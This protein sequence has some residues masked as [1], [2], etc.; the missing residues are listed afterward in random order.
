MTTE[1][2]HQQCRRARQLAEEVVGPVQWVTDTMGHCT[3]PGKT[4]HEPGGS[5]FPCSL[6]LEGLYGRPTLY[7]DYGICSDERDAAVEQIESAL[8]AARR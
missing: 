2:P 5:D 8:K 6:L 7:C 3:C 1:V 4:L